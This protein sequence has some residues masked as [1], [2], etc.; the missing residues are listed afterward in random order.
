[1]C[2][3]LSVSPAEFQ[4]GS[5][6]VWSCCR[7]FCK[8]R[9]YLKGEKY[10]IIL[11]KVSL[12]DTSS[13]LNLT[14]LHHFY[15]LQFFI[16]NIFPAVLTGSFRD[17]RH[18]LCFL[19]PAW[20]VLWISFQL[21]KAMQIY[22]WRIYTSKTPAGKGRP[23]GHQ[24]L[25]TLSDV[26]DSKRIVPYQPILLCL[27]LC[28]AD[29]LSVPPSVPFL[30]LLFLKCRTLALYLVPGIQNTGVGW[31]SVLLFFP[32][33]SLLTVH[34]CF[35]KHIYY[36]SRSHSLGV[37]LSPSCPPSTL[38]RAACLLPF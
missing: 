9:E 31:F 33:N 18:F 37:L 38:S 3:S 8:S 4:R 2:E 17:C 6:E 5:V 23:E 25:R 13:L 21:V 14:A 34:W 29:P 1:M 26:A 15:R 30:V 16:Q 19:L 11:G 27:P 12:T 28:R 10:V 24:E 22:S 20:L 32:D 36:G 35:P 7:C